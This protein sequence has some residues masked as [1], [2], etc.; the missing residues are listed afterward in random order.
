MHKEHWYVGLAYKK[1]PIGL[2][3]ETPS[4][5]L[6]D[7]QKCLELKTVTWNVQK[8]DFYFSSYVERN[9]TIWTRKVSSSVSIES[10]DADA[11]KSTPEDLY[12]I[13]F[14]YKP[15]A[16]S[17][18]RCGQGFQ[19]DNYDRRVEGIGNIPA[20]FLPIFFF[21]FRLRNIQNKYSE[22]QKPQLVCCLQLSPGNFK[23][24]RR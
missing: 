16:E 17:F 24:A 22:L 14:N 4:Y 5:Q 3:V 7:E 12:E 23:S 1:S 9:G 20:K 15:N 11:I 13:K 8:W 19:F 10:I 18:V 2:F 6:N 21:I